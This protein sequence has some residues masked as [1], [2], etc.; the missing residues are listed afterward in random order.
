[1]IEGAREQFPGLPFTLHGIPDG[2]GPFV[3]FTWTL[4]STG[5]DAVAAG[6]DV[7]RLDADGR[8]GEVIGFLDD[9]TAVTR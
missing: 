4:A 3:R 5:G 2:H 8:I 7:V 1:M 9:V 6:T